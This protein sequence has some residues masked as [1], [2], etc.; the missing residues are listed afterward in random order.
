MLVLAAVGTVAC[1]VP[2]ASRQAVD[3]LVAQ[4]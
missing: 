4:R 1:L 3:P 2:R